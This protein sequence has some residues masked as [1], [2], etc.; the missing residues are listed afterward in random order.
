MYA[1]LSAKALT[2]ARPTPAD[3]PVTTTTSRFAISVI[4]RSSCSV[5]AFEPSNFPTF[6]PSNL[7]K[8]RPCQLPQARCR[9]H[10][11]RFWRGLSYYMDTTLVL[12]HLI[13]RAAVRMAAEA[14]G[15][16]GSADAQVA[17]R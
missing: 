4:P 5:T 11:L 2:V 6:E 16:A 14:Y 13:V 1:P 15:N 8:Q 9:T 3:A 12:K 7:A 10:V 17:K